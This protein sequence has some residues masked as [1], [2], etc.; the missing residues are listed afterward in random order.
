M[1]LEL[2]LNP[3]LSVKVSVSP[4]V[5]SRLTHQM[6]SKSEPPRRCF[7]TGLFQIGPYPI[8]NTPTYTILY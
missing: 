6:S 5:L 7:Y 3:F 4:F 2:D 1:A 8:T